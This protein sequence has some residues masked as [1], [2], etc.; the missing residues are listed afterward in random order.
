MKKKLAII[1]PIV[2]REKTM[3]LA[4]APFSDLMKKEISPPANGN[5]INNA[6]K[7]SNAANILNAFGYNFQNNWKMKNSMIATIMIK[8]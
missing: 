5:Q 4:L 2:K 7:L 3:A 1:T 6:G 8:I